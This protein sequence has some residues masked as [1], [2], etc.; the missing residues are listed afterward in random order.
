M[1]K[2]KIGDKVTPKDKV[3]GRW[4]VLDG[5]PKYYIVGKVVTPSNAP[6]SYDLFYDGHKQGWAWESEIEFYMN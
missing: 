3:N 6:I 1:S 4:R 5:D 2:F